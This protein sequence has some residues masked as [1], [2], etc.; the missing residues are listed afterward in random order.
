VLAA[1][2]MP[3]DFRDVSGFRNIIAMSR[4]GG[5]TFSKPEIV[6][7]APHRPWLKVDNKTGK[8]YLQ[9]IGFDPSVK[10]QSDPSKQ[11]GWVVTWQPH[12]AAHSEPRHM[13]GPGFSAMGHIAVANGVVAS[14]FAIGGGMFGGGQA[15]ATP[16]PAALQ[17]LVKNGATTCSGQAPCVFFQTS[18][19]DGKTWARHQ[20]PVP[21][22]RI[23]GF[24]WLAADPGKADRYAIGYTGANENSLH[25]MVTDDSGNSWSGPFTVPAAGKGRTFKAW[26]DYGPTGVLGIMWKQVPDELPN[27][28]P[29]A[30][31]AQ[32][33]DEIRIA[34]MERR[35]PAFN[36]YAAISCDGGKTWQPPVRVNAETSPAGVGGL[37]DMSDIK[38]DAKYVHLVWGDTRAQS[39]V[40]N[41][42]GAIG[43]VQAYYGRVPFSVA[44]KGAQ[45]GRK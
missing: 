18:T 21:P 27:A 12:L 22:G 16:V 42:P 37:D 6:E 26:M 2:V 8:V 9:V 39:R 44:A 3:A 14:V 32:T 36:V 34:S 4:D 31:K 38:L 19:D 35:S 28:A 17:G 15:P 25:A 43:G 5:K 23:A 1:K 7:S 30:P 41:A 40:T 33:P 10:D 11:D 13:G 24:L 20:V 29:A 45:C